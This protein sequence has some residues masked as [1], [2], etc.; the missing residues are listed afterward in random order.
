MK[1]SLRLVSALLC[2]VVLFTVAGCAGGN[3]QPNESTTAAPPQ[4]TSMRVAGLKGPTGIGLVKL[5]EDSEKGTAKN[6]YTFALEAA[7][8]RIVPLLSK[9]E[10]DIAALPLNLAATLYNK[11]NGSVQLL[12]V[13]TL[14]VLYILEKGNTINSVKDLRGKTIYASGQAATPEYVLNYILIANGL[15]PATDVRIEYK[16]EHT[17]LANLAA[18]G[19]VV[20]SMLP[21]PFVTTVLN[22]N[23]DMR[24][25]LN[26]TDEWVK[27][28]EINGVESTLAMGCLVVRTAFAQEN[29]E[30]LR[31]FL[32]EYRDSVVFVKN[33]VDAAAALVEKQAILP[34]AALAAKAIPNCNIVF[35]EGADMKLI[36]KQNLQVLF[37]ANP[38]A[39][40]GA[41]PNND[42]Y[43]GV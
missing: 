27:A 2:A 18:A 1:K 19:N 23:A 36:A 39:I 35:I 6:D 25:A 21:E 12:A 4:R 10:V 9:G 15:Y 16:T 22:K 37:D 33:N 20:V 41:E 40:G 3:E 26:L 31:V 29:P 42:F 32:E 30:A 17:E 24:I 8:D 34:S 7:P 28:C 5:M 43:F 14:G 38:A 13:N 11:T